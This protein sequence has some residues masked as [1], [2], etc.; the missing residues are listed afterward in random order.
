MFKPESI[1]TASIGKPRAARFSSQ[2]ELHELNRRRVIFLKNR[3]RFAYTARLSLGSDPSPT[4]G[5]L[6]GD[7]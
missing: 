3:E 4:P 7:E 6:A 1:A 2:K 5:Q